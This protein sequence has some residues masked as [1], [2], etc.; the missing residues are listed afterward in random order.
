MRPSHGHDQTIING[1]SRIGTMS[2]GHAARWVDE[3]MAD[4]FARKAVSFIEDAAGQP[5]FLYFA[6]HDPHVPRAPHPRF[7]GASGCGLRGDAIVQLD[8]CVGEILGTLDR[9]GLAGDTLVLLTSD[10]GPVVDDGY[11]DGAVKS[12]NGHR[13]AGPLRGGKYSNFEGGTRIPLVL[14]WPGHAR[15]GVSDALVSLMDLPASFASLTDLQLA[16]GD[17]PD[18]VDVL[19]ALLGESPC[20]R[21]ALVQQGGCLA[22][23][24]GTHKLIEASGGPAYAPLV[25]IE[26]GNAP[27]LQL[28]DLEADLGES[29]D[30]SRRMPER[31]AAMAEALARKRG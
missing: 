9:L 16:P 25:D 13:P 1:I 8:W 6:T 14:R 21:G 28:Y 4:T 27:H 18:S 30:L 23:R 15:Q 22:L 20:G 29:D 11:E 24:Q 12:L 17:A 2:G 31:V 26:L 7:R 10:N 3:E 5:F 19:P